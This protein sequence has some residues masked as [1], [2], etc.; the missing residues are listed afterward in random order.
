MN[1]FFAVNWAIQVW[2]R[3]DEAFYKPS[4]STLFEMRELYPEKIIYRQGSL[5]K[6]MGFSLFI[7]NFIQFLF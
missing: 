4:D 6:R 5:R 7:N 2:R 3:F 1:L